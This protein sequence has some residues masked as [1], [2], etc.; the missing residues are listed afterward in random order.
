MDHVVTAEPTP[1]RG[2]S[3]AAGFAGAGLVAGL[4]LA[5]LTTANAQDPT[6]APSAPSAPSA[7]PE[8]PG[9]PG[10][11]GR[12]DGRRGGKNYGRGGPFGNLGGVMLHGE[13]TAPD[14]D[15]G[16]QVLATQ[17]GEATAV[18]ATSLTVRSEDGFSRTYAVTDD[19]L[20]NAG[21]VGIGDVEVGHEVRVLAVVEDGAARAVRVMDI[22]AVGELAQKWRPR[23]PDAPKPSAT[24]GSGTPS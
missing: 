14:P 21:N 18:S 13:F 9:T 16:Y 8:A 11:R 19:T 7:R 20:V 1:R 2:R 17:V 5:G 22:T 10:E 23:R 24:P 12:M 6:P 15:G 3:Y 4:V